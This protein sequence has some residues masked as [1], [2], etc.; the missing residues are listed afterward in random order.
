MAAPRRS[1]AKATPIDPEALARRTPS[2]VMADEIVAAYADLKP[3]VQRIMS[4]EGL[5]EEGRF[6]AISKFRDSLQTP[7]DPMRHPV[8]ATEAGLAYQES[9][10]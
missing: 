10:S 4:A 5:V 2:E 1:R 6:H 7:G 3:S 8:K 9:L